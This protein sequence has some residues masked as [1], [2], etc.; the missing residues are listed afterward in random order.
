LFPA[1]QG[2]FDGS[3]PSLAGL[4]NDRVIGALESGLMTES[5]VAALLYLIRSPDAHFL[6]V[7]CLPFH[8]L[9]SI[10]YKFPA[11][12]DSR[13]FW[14]GNLRDVL[15]DVAFAAIQVLM[16]RVE[17]RKTDDD[18]NPD[19]VDDLVKASLQCQG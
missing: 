4:D 19:L 5:E 3:R 13:V 15:F 16:A 14:S 18:Y 10:L 1:W 7:P 6:K 9:I 17:S 8:S 11:D 12:V 2:S